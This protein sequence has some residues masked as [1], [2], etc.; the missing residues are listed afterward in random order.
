MNGFPRVRERIVLRKVDEEVVA[1][2]ES[3]LSVPGAVARVLCGRGLSSFE[4]C[5]SFFNPSIDQFNDPFL[6]SSMERA[7]A[8]IVKAMEA[9][10]K[11]VVHGDYDVDGITSTVLVV[12]V[13]RSLGAQCDYYLP[14]RLTDGYG[15]SVDGVRNIAGSG[16]TLMITVDCGISA[17][18]EI[19]AASNLGLDCIVTDHHEAHHDIPRAYAI[20]DPKVPG[21]TYPFEHLAGVGVALKLC[22]AIAIYFKRPEDLWQRYLDLVALGTAADIVPMVRENRV[23]TSLGFERMSS[24]TVCGLRELMDQQGLWGRRISTSNAVFQIAPC[25]NAAGRIGDPDIA[26]KLLLTDNRDEARELASQLRSANLERRELDAAVALEAQSWVENNA[27]PAVDFGIVAGGAN[28]HAGVIGI[29][30]SKIVERYHRPAILFSVGPDGYARGSG[31]SIPSVHLLDALN[32]CSDLLEGYGGHAAAAGMTIKSAL[33]GEFRARFNGIIRSM[34]VPED[35]VPVVTADAEAG[36][37]AVTPKLF[38]IIKRMEPFGPGNMRPV[39][40]ARD[41]RHRTSPRLAGKTHLKMSLVEDGIALDAIGFNFGDRYQEVK[42]ASSI[43]VAYTVDQNEWNGSTTLQM[44][45][46]GISL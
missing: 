14:N 12:R 27:D 37:P 17:V 46:K 9:N 16:A 36:I 3:Q 35:F 10:E 23:I 26:V 6:F 1:R 13:L 20:I 30:A 25:I 8:R 40:L 11:I 2:L 24:D 34:T 33:I 39:F 15:I 31:R 21:C 19:A 22:Q 43:S 29:V 42:N 4:E 45:V 7:V 28:W 41:V 5:R 38:R 18:N 44:K 32:N